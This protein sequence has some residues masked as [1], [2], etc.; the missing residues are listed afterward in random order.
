MVRLEL[1]SRDLSLREC[2]LRDGGFLTIG[3]ESTNDIVIR[4]P[5]VSKESGV[6]PVLVVLEIIDLKDGFCFFAGI[7][8]PQ[9]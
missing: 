8:R 7:N 6:F 4:D 5:A 9:N 1:T 2:T 3:R